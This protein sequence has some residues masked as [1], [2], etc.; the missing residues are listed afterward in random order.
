MIVELAATSPPVHL[1]PPVWPLCRQPVHFQAH[2]LSYTLSGQS[3]R[4]ADSSVQGGTQGGQCNGRGSGCDGSAASEGRGVLLGGLAGAATGAA[5]IFEGRCGA[6][7][8]WWGRLLQPPL[9]GRLVSAWRALDARALDAKAL[10]GRRQPW[11]GPGPAE[12]RAV[13]MEGGRGHAERQAAKIWA[14]WACR[15]GQMEG[16]AVQGKAGQ[17]LELADGS[18][19]PSIRQERTVADAGP[20]GVGEGDGE[21]AGEG[22]GEGEGLSTACTPAP[23]P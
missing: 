12:G 4:G 7:G 23:W 17:V 2:I 16:G 13:G 3:R 19:Q 1:A 20:E 9:E 15:A 11:P 14:H 18:S 6:V 21:G 5:S 22:A 8:A 10:S